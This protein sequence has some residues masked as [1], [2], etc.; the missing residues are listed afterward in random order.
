MCDNF[1]QSFAV[2]QENETVSIRDVSRGKSCG[3]ICNI[4]GE[5][6][7]A[8]QGDVRAWH[9][10]H[11]NGS[12]CEGATESALHLAAKQVLLSA[13]H[14]LLPGVSLELDGNHL[15]ISEKNAAISSMQLEIPLNTEFGMFKPDG[16]MNSNEQLYCIE[17]HV[18]HAVDEKKQ[19]KI[20]SLGIPTTEIT[21]DPSMTEEWTWELL[22]KVVLTNSQNRHW[23]FH[24]KVKQ[25]YDQYENQ[26]NLYEPVLGALQYV[27]TRYSLYG[28]PVRLRQYHNFI[29]LWA[30]YDLRILSIIKSISKQLGGRWNPKYKT[31]N[32]GT[33]LGV[34]LPQCLEA[35]GAVKENNG[36]QDQC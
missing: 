23:V 21:I 36:N 18:S 12:D 27:E 8:R 34:L 33:G 13:D 11:E 25:F 28:V 30:P 4:C 16:L 24:P 20:E 6:L 10:A 1:L 9:F 22:E 17:V 7:I 3:C 32:Y 26:N 31:W 35:V 14:L 29:T 2:T 19:L 5:R 15:E